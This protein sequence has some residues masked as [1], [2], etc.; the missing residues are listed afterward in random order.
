MPVATGALI[1]GGVALA[2]QGANMVAQ[3][4]LNKKNRKWQEEQ[5]TTKYERDIDQRDYQNWYNSPEQQMERFE[6]AGLNPHLIYGKGTAGQQTS[7]VQAKASSY[8]GKLPQIKVDP[9][10]ELQKYQQLKKTKQET[11]LVG[12]AINSQKLD[13]ALK[14]SSLQSNIDMKMQRLKTEIQNTQNAKLKAQY[15][16]ELTELTKQKQAVANMQ[17]NWAKQGIT[18][19]DNMIFRQIATRLPDFWELWKESGGIKLDKSNPFK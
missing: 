17:A 12:E 13:N 8:E 19:S 5:N 10:L 18:A 14:S 4:K 2:G 7:S 1:A 11:D 9:L 6:A 3:G 16:T 15:L